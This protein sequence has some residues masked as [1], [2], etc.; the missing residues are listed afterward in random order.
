MAERTPAPGAPRA[1]VRWLLV[2]SLALNLLLVGVAVGAF[3]GPAGRDGQMPRDSVLP[4]VQAFEPRERRALGRDLRARMRAAGIDRSARRDGYRDAVQLLRAE[5]FDAAAFEALL[6]RQFAAAARLQSEGRAALIE[7]LSGMKP[8]ARAAYAAR[9][10]E[11]L[12]RHQRRADGVRH[13]PSRGAG[14]SD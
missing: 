6:Q 2:A 5:P 9:L 12:E 1:W 11:L 3:F 14:G 4:Y 7:R 13:Q 8:E 10:E